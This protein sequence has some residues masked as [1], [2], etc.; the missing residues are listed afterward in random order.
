MAIV[1]AIITNSKSIEKAFLT[2]FETW[3]TEYVNDIH[4]EQ[5]F[6]DMSQWEW[7]RET[8]R[9][10]GEIVASPRDI[11]DLG[12]LYR[13]GVNSFDL[14][15]SGSTITARWH[16]DAKNSSG[17][18]YAAYVHDGTWFMDARPFTEDVAPP[19]AQ[20]F[21]RKEPGKA[22]KLEVQAELNKIS[23]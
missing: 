21:F 17:Q 18:E 6:D 7:G 3:A 23:R 11:Y 2:A 22:L 16:W 5:Q 15:K 9:R 19:V 12:N 1:N 20:A 4:W 10:N 8:K 13:S 14:D